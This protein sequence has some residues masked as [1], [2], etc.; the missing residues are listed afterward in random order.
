MNFK[1]IFTITTLTLA[2]NS[3]AGWLEDLSNSSDKIQQQLQNLEKVD[4]TSI[5]SALSNEDI[6]AGLKEA[7]IK[8]AGYAVDN[9]GKSD[10]FLKNTDVKIPMPE[11]LKEVESL[12]RQFGNDKY[13][14]EFVTTMNRAAESAVPLTLEII[15]QGVTGMSIDDAN[16]IL[17]GPDDAATQYLKKTGGNKLGAKILPI[18]KDATSRSGVTARYKEMV[19][20]LGFAGQF[21]NL[22]DY[23]I[24]TYVTK[25]TMAGLFTMIAK[26]EK[27]IRDD[28]AARTT[29]LLKSVFGYK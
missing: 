23:D 3:Y 26:E 25:K 21:L 16:G 11:K 10:G 15:K 18:V 24:D 14:D 27:K 13:A 5:Q 6:I 9:L 29:E 1:I 22:D 20:S 8:G 7:L 28:P 19:G 17:Q 12:L 4:T 2:S